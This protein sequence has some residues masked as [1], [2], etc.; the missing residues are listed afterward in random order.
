MSPINYWLFKSEPTAYSYQDLQNEDDHTAEWDGVRNYQ[1][2]NLM[3]DEMKIGDRVLF[4]DYYT[5][6]ILKKYI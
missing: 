2:R 4:Y 6:F 3:R 1:A 5:V